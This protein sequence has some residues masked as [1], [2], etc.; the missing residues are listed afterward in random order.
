MLE[1][2]KS[3]KS[4]LPSPLASGLRRVAA[5]EQRVEDVVLELLR[6]VEHLAER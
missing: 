3:L 1:K 5:L 2:L 6:V 4:T